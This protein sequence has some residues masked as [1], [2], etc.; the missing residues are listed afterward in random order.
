MQNQ[1]N[2]IASA[3]SHFLAEVQFQ[4]SRLIGNRLGYPRGRVVVLASAHKVGSTWLFDMIAELGKFKKTPPPRSYNDTGTLIIDRDDL[5]NYFR[6]LPGRRIFKSH[7][8]PPNFNYDRHVKLVN[9]FRDP[10]DVIV[11]NIFYLAN[12][13]PQLGGWGAEFKSLSESERIL[14]F[15]RKGDFCLTRLENWFAHKSGFKIRYEELLINCAGQLSK[16]FDWLELSVSPEDIEKTVEIHSFKNRS[17]RNPGQE[18]INSFF[19]KG[20]SGDWKN[21]F[22]RNCIRALKTEKGRRWNRLLLDMQY[23]QA[24]D[25]NL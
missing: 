22:D 8:Y 15:I 3:Y 18:N 9:I 12:L 17:N 19:R 7:S 16:L 1:R 24:E 14:L 23:E 11:S 5:S 21:Y 4:S 2:K 10:R 13:D 6:Y 20:I 25:W